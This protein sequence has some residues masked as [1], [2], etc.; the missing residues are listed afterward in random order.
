MKK[1]QKIIVALLLFSAIARAQIGIGT[2]VPDASAVLDLSST[3]KGF[4]LPRMTSAEQA[5]L[6][7][8][9]K[10]LAIFNTTTNQIENNI[11]DGIDSVIWVG[12]STK[13]ITAPLGTNTT[14]LA[15]T[16]FVLANTG[17]YRFLE[18]VDAV[19]TNATTEVVIS[20]MSVTPSAGTYAVSFNSQYNNSPIL[21]AV[22]T[23]NTS[24]MTDL[25]RVYNELKAIQNPV[26]AH[27][28]TFGS[29]TLNPGVYSIIGASTVTGILTLDALGDPNA[30]FIIKATGSMTLAAAAEIK[31]INNASAGNVFWLIEGA[32]NVGGAGIA[33]GIFISNGSAV[34]IG[35]GTSLEGRMFTTLGALA[36]GPGTAIIPELS[37]TINLGSLSS[38]IMFTNNGAINNTGISTITGDILSNIGATGSLATATITGT[39]FDPNVG[40]IISTETPNTTLAN[41]TFGIFKEGI[42]IPNS[43]RNLKSN[44]NAASIA[45]QSLVTVNGNQAID[46]RW[47]TDFTKLTLGNRSLTLIQVH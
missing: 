27:I 17:T 41:V 4:L 37:N 38:F 6:S 35:A 22:M 46:I 44:G 34:S 15:T 10:G 7:K 30:V 3:T 42:A 45:L 39:I 5:A 11:G 28:A 36:F 19:T 12:A 33:K 9:A 16:E 32:I 21:A 18:S 8:P 31:L 29:E 40:I 43:I 2:L 25:V 20:G 14:Q 24:F 13:G 23:A 47:K 26:I 1:N